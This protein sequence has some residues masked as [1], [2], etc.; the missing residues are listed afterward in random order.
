MSETTIDLRA[1]DLRPGDV[2]LGSGFVVEST[3]RATGRKVTFEGR[4]PGSSSKTVTWGAS[5]TLRVRR[6]A[7]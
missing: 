5:T 4:Y 7:P 6:P 2:C 1:R 3:P